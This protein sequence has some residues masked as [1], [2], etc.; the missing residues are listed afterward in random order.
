MG[1]EAQQ[2][3]YGS[4]MPVTFQFKSVPDQGKRINKVQPSVETCVSCRTEKQVHIPIRETAI[5][6]LIPSRLSDFTEAGIIVE[7]RRVTSA[8]GEVSKFSTARS[9]RRKPKEMR[10]DVTKSTKMLDVKVKVGV[11][12][13]LTAHLIVA[14]HH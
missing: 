8:Q 4:A 3:R 6:V 7:L 1:N 11:S 10:M 14:G 12:P 9:S 13:S 2:T 5:Q